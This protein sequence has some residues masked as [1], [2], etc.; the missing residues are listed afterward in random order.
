MLNTDFFRILSERPQM[1]LLYFLS[2]YGIDIE[3]LVFNVRM[4]MNKEI[5]IPSLNEQLKNCTLIQKLD[6]TVI[7][8]Q[9]KLSGLQQARSWAEQNLFPTSNKIT[10]KV[11]VDEFDGAWTSTNI[12][13]ICK[14]IKDRSANGELLSVTRHNG[15][16]R[17]SETGRKD[18]SS[19]DKSNYKWV[20]KGDLVYNSM[21]MW[22]GASGLSKYDGIVSPAYTVVKLE[23]TVD[24]NF[25]SL[26][27]KNDP[28]V[29]IFRRHSKGLTSDTWNL[30]YPELSK[31]RISYPSLAEQQAIAKVFTTI[32]ARIKSEQQL[33]ADLQEVKRWAL[34]NMFV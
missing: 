34:D 19:N 24:G 25:I 3:K 11:R 13:D 12:G 5:L 21:R 23:P 9:H 30:K 18:N 14:E 27:F 28:L 4:W 2:S 7:S 8:H 32:D 31:I 20:S 29:F 17:F 16:V 33:I 15:V 6:D 26:L 10:P 1:Y 22:Q